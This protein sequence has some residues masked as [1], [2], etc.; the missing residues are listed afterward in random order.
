MEGFLKYSLGVPPENIIK[1]IDGQAT[2]AAIMQ[3]LESFRTNRNIRDGDAILIYF[4]GHGGRAETPIDWNPGN[5]D[6]KIEMICP[7]NMALSSAQE[8]RVSG[9]PD[10]F[11]GALVTN[12]AREKSDNIVRSSFLVRRAF[13]ERD[14][15]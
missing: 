2:K 6:R 1:H 4:A 8:N 15:Y 7:V 3:T 12:L 14:S 9:I 10:I 11:I 5:T 13:T